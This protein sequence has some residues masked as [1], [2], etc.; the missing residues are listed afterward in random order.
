MVPK[1]HHTTEGAE[2]AG[3]PAADRVVSASARQTAAIPHRQIRIE[4]A[5]R[6]ELAAANGRKAGGRQGGAGVLC[7]VA[8]PR[9]G[10]SR[11]Q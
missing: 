11:C 10:V 7:D 2:V 8:V 5:S 3:L 6:Q 9:S 4:R 1:D